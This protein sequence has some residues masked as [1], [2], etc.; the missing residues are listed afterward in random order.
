MWCAC[1]CGVHEW[2]LHVMCACVVCTCVM[3]M[4]GVYMCG[5][6]IKSVEV[7]NHAKAITGLF[8]MH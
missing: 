4:C 5:V 8:P 1:V 2:N 3:C 7:T 6:Y